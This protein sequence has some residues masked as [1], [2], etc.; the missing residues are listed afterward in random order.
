MRRTREKVV[1]TVPSDLVTL[2]EQGD[3]S[4]LGDGV[5]AE[6]N[7]TRWQLLQQCCNNVGMQAGARRVNDNDF[8]ACNIIECL[9]AGS[10]DS[11]GVGAVKFGDV[12]LH[13]ADSVGVD[14][15]QR[16]VAAANG[17]ADGANAGVKIENWLIGSERHPGKNLGN[18]TWVPDYFLMIFELSNYQPSTST[19]ASAPSA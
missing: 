16:D 8:L 12:A 18:F 2:L 3:I 19:L 15:H 13:F 5:A 11:A 1:A 17:Q 14:F 10:E 7:D 4:G 9:F 6:I